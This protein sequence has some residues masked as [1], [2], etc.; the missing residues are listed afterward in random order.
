ME[1][2]GGQYIHSENLFNEVDISDRGK[3]KGKRDWGRGT[4]REESRG[5][6][7]FSKMR[8]AHS[9]HP[10]DCGGNRERDRGKREKKGTETEY[11]R[12][13]PTRVNRPL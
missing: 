10:I 3:R 4:D 5:N 11:E 2:N 7:R 6:A 9:L 12:I 13:H 8:P 1:H